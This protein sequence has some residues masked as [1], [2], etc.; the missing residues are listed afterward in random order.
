MKKKLEEVAEGVLLEKSTFQRVDRQ[1][2][3]LKRVIR[4]F[5]KGSL[6]K[7]A[8]KEVGTNY[9]KTAK[10]AVKHLEMGL[11]LLEDIAADLE[12]GN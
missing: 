2:E 1:I 6:V 12:L 5:S 3:D 4:V 11:D 8:E 9:S 7:D 10:E